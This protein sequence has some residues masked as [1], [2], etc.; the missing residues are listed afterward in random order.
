VA[1]LVVLA[2][3]ACATP[4]LG[5]WSDYGKDDLLLLT[6]LCSE[7]VGIDHSFGWMLS[8]RQSSLHYS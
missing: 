7:E 6:K 5:G 3:A 4:W 8:L 1:A 2:T